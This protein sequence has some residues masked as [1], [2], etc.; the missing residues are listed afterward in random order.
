MKLCFHFGYCIWDIRLFCNVESSPHS[1]SA[2]AARLYLFTFE[3]KHPLRALRR[4]NLT[5][6]DLGS[7]FSGDEEDNSVLY[8]WTTAESCGAIEIF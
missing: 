6:A 4:I 3:R 7:L 2:E 1:Q 5:Q 8:M